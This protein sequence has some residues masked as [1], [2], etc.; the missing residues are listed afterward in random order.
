MQTKRS[1]KLLE[2]DEVKAKLEA[3][4]KELRELI[5]EISKHDDEFHSEIGS[6][7]ERHDQS[8]T[9]NESVMNEMSALDLIREQANRSMVE[10]GAIGR[11]SGN[12][13]QEEND[14]G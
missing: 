9:H 5:K 3:K 12:V 14:E 11:G 4:E 2:L 13:I 7:V 10:K 8:L 6:F 1:Q